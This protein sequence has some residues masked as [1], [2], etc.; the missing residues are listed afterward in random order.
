MNNA[1]LSVILAVIGSSALS[2]FV[3]FLITR[4]DSKKKF[5]DKLKVLEKDG[6]R[7]QLML[8]IFLRPE[9]KHE[10][11]TVAEQ[12]FGKLNGDWYATPIFNKWCIEYDVAEPAWFNK[13]E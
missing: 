8:L 7:T 1:L 3:I 12:Y 10:I 5:E 4:H 11:L 6:L 9:D 13:E 2:S